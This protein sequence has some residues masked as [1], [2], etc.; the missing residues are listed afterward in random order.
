[1]K[2][3]ISN[4]RFDTTTATQ[5]AEWDSSHAPGDFH[6]EREA[7][8]RSAKGAWFLHWAGGP[9]S[10][11]AVRVGSVCRGGQGITPFTELEACNWLQKRQRVAVLEAHFS[12]HLQDA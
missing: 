8:Y 10:S 5:M 1:M 11:R 6:H 3:I 9:M 12:S 2:V 7:L 4:K